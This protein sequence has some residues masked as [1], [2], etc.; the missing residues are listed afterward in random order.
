MLRI[1]NNRVTSQIR[2]NLNYTRKFSNYTRKFSNAITSESNKKIDDDFNIFS[3]SLGL[4]SLIEKPFEF[5]TED[6]T[7]DTCILYYKLIDPEYSNNL[8]KRLCVLMKNLDKNKRDYRSLYKKIKKTP[9]TSDNIPKYIYKIYF[10]TILLKRQLFD[11]ILHELVMIRIAKKIFKE[12]SITF[13]ESDT[14]RGGGDFYKLIMLILGTIIV[15][16]ATNPFSDLGVVEEIIDKEQIINKDFEELKEIG[17][18]MRSRNREQLKDIFAVKS[19]VT[20]SNILNGKE[21]SNL[22]QTIIFEQLSKSLGEINYKYRSYRQDIIDECK[23]TFA[24]VANIDNEVAALGTFSELLIHSA[25][26]NKVEYSTTLQESVKL[27]GT[28]LVSSIPDMIKSFTDGVVNGIF[29]TKDNSEEIIKTTMQN[30]LNKHIQETAEKLIDEQE[31]V[32]SII[33]GRLFM[34]IQCSYMP[35]PE[36][37]VYKV[38]KVSPHDK[39]DIVIET[40]YATE[41]TGKIVDSLALLISK[42]KYLEDNSITKPPGTVEVLKLQREKVFQ[43]LRLANYGPF[44][45]IP[46]DSTT[47]STWDAA[48]FIVDAESKFRTY[49][50]DVFKLIDSF[51]ITKQKSQEHLNAI[52]QLGKINREAKR[53]MNEEMWQNFATKW[54]IAE[55]AGENVIDTAKKT[56]EGTSEIITTVINSGSDIFLRSATDIVDK[57]S[58]PFFK[59]AF[60]GAT[61]IGLMILFYCAIPLINLY[62]LRNKPPTPATAAPPPPEPKA[63]GLV[64]AFDRTFW[65]KV[66]N[67]NKKK[68]GKSQKKRKTSKKSKTYKLN[69]RNRSFVKRK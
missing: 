16:F 67:K 62:I 42:I 51:S 30:K 31:Q 23:S 32:F 39:I 21:L 49:Q 10:Q 12:L 37:K 34:D 4:R 24:A 41:N 64:L 5:L 19:T 15:T 59:L 52:E 50:V 65:L 58:K 46:I 22:R 69:K 14:K 61:G 26:S 20:L 60:M 1:T 27:M 28:E 57:A 54:E 47:D 35:T 44:L 48:K 56:A 2:G 63:K 17:Q 45:A 53:A 3:F 25:T 55:R 13:S 11:F 66:A 33:A 68:G 40:T 8:K 6:I 7:K 18:S 36:Y 43:L 29:S 38:Y 9:T